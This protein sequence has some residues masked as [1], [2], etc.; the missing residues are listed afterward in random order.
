MS[1]FTPVATVT[2]CAILVGGLGTR[3]GARTQHLPKPLMQCGDRPFLAWLMREMQRYG[4][5]EFLLLAGHLSEEIERAVDG[6]RAF[7]PR[8]AR[9]AISVE[10]RRAGTGGALHHARHLLQDRFLLC[11]GDSVFA[12]PLGPLLARAASTRGHWMMLRRMTETG[13][14]GVVTLGTDDETVQRFAPSDEAGG[15][16]LINAGIYLLER[17]LVGDLPDECSLEA[18]ILPRLAATG[19]LRAVTGSGWFLDIGVAHDLSRAQ[20]ELPAQLRRG[21][22][23]LDRDGVLNH[24]HGWVGTRERFEWTPDGRHAVRAACDAGRHVFVVTNQSGIARGLYTEAD[25][26]ELH[27]WILDE[28][29]L[30]GG[31]IDDLRFCPYHADA[32]VARYRQESDWRKP[33]PGMILDLM[34]AWELDSARCTMIGDQA[35]DVAAARAAG[36]TGHL[37]KGGDLLEILAT[38]GV[39]AQAGAA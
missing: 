26:S 25:F 6:L 3:L 27:R 28:I 38:E 32:A 7:L 13:R 15:P 30:A 1:A 37:T 31:T 14:Y 9:I 20:H 23:F 39:F 33:A 8:P 5:E 36:I 12:A 17:D 35:H 4:V 10:P 2:Q 16:G 19:M 21:A 22:L 18:D 29:Q 34:R 11:N 24:D